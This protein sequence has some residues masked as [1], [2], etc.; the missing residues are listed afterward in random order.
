MYVGGTRLFR[1][2]DRGNT[3]SE[4][5]LPAGAPSGEIA[6]ASDRDGIYVQA[7]GQCQAQQ[8]SIW[9]THDGASTWE[10]WPP[11]GIGDAGC[12]S[13][14]SMVDPQHAFLV[15]A[16]GAAAVTV[17]AGANAGQA[18]SASRPLPIPPGFAVTS[19]GDA[20][21]PGP[22]R[23]F[24]STLL[25]DAFGQKTGSGAEFAYRSTDGGANWTYASTAPIAMRIAFV[26][27]S[28]WLQISSPN[29]LR[30]TTD[31]GATW[32]A[33]TTDYQQAA[34]VAPQIVFGDANVGYA[35]VRGGLQRTV[36]GG[37]HWTSLPTPGTS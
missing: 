35:T 20:L 3:W 28:R 14:P 16:D 30:E 19:P 22:V 18:W 21:L 7:S 31:G 29:D 9:L 4:H 10:K 8:L 1:S 15:S 11:Q 33:Y 34:G 13:R 24:G 6:F 25:L 27:A 36:D 37:A 26:T 12:K 5:G 23:G 2:L 32:H 17:Y